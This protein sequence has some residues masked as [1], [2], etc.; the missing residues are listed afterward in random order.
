MQTLIQ[1]ATRL[2]QAADA[3]R[4]WPNDDPDLTRIHHSLLGII[5]VAVA[6]AKHAQTPRP[7]P[8]NPITRSHFYAR[9]LTTLRPQLISLLEQLAAGDISAVPELYHIQ[10]EIANHTAHLAEAQADLT[11]SN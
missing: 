11:R 7:A 2:S 4:I 9:E 10:S 1:E 8:R 5:A 3:T 6:A